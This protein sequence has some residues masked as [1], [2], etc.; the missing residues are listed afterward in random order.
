MLYLFLVNTHQARNSCLHLDLVTFGRV[1]TA[2][3]GLTVVVAG[4]ATTA[5]VDAV[6]TQPHQSHHHRISHCIHRP[7]HPQVP[8]ADSS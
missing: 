5:V 4:V 1:A 6:I 8:L 3:D 7:H 2:V